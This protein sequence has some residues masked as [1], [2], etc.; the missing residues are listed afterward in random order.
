M[1]GLAGLPLGMR[2]RFLAPDPD[3]PASALGEII[4][5]QHGDITAI[6]E[7]TVG[8][9]VATYEFEN[10]S[11]EV[12]RQVAERVPVHPAPAAL[13]MSQDRRAEKDGF[14]SVGVPTAPYRTV[15]TLGEL[16]SA[17]DELGYPCML[18]TRRMGYDG[19]GQTVLRGPDD[20]PVAWAR[21]GEHLLILESFV[22]FD[23]EL[24]ILAVRS[25]EGEILY[26]PL[27]ENEHRD[28]ILRQTVA[29]A[30]DVTTELRSTAE[31][32]CRRIM[33]VLNYVGVIAIELFQS[34]TELLV[35]EMAPRVH[36]SGHWTQ[37]G[38]SCCQFENHLRAVAGL[39]LGVIEPV[40]STTMINLIGEVPCIHH[41]LSLP[42][43]HL[44]LYGKEPR[45]GRKL[46]HVNVVGHQPET[47]TELRRLT[48]LE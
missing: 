39:P 1:L 2:F 20:L 45:P 41:L 18:K 31:S 23:R 24:S 37:D 22:D 15:A 25:G 16:R 35:N 32:Y 38:T 6:E 34:G 8:M 42:G 40:Q 43:V 29:P 12:V 19:K 7:F 26:Y 47:V 27:A 46:G 14:R 30:P 28:G 48:G 3:V 9:D 17:A 4:Q 33:E 10:V 13:E 21:L 44:H 36:N 5:R 11:I